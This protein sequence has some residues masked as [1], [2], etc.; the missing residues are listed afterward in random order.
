MTTTIKIFIS[1]SIHVQNVTLKKY[2]DYYDLSDKHEVVQFEF[3]YEL[4]IQLVILLHQIS[5][6]QLCYQN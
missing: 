4:V 5:V 1:I 6:Q 3:S 2:F